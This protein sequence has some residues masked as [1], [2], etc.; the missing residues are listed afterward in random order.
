MCRAEQRLARN[1]VQ[2]ELQRRVATE[3]GRVAR[4]PLAS[5]VPGRP[6]ADTVGVRGEQAVDCGIN[7]RTFALLRSRQRQIQRADVVQVDIH[8]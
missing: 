6:A 7:V 2:V 1:V 5:C 3:C 8:R 4:E